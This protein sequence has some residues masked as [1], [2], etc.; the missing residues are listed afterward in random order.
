LARVSKLNFILPAK[1]QPQ[2]SF[3]LH[4]GYVPEKIMQIKCKIPI[5]NRVVPWGLGNDKL[6]LY[7]V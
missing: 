2:A 7:S 5:Y 6:N 1:L 4:Q 3:I